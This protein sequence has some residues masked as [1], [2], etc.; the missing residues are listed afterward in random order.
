LS[1]IARFNSEANEALPA[2]AVGQNAAPLKVPGTITTNT[3]SPDRDNDESAFLAQPLASVLASRQIAN[4]VLL[5]GFTDEYLPRRSVN[6]P[7]SNCEMLD[8]SGEFT[9]SY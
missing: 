3:R 9:W 4:P 8:G 7:R 5:N 6:E 2:C 1:P